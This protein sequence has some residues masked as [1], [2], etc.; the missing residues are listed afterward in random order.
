MTVA[1]RSSLQ[2]IRS[3]DYALFNCDQV[4]INVQWGE[5]RSLPPLIK[6]QGTKMTSLDEAL[7]RLEYLLSHMRCIR[8]LDLH[9]DTSVTKEMDAMIEKFLD[10]G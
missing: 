5:S 8:T 4:S 2:I 6:I 3:T 7:E 1:L 10:A 9:L